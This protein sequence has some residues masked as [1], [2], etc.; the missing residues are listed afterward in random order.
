M[1]G[2]V[3]L[4]VISILA[5]AFF[6]LTLWPNDPVPSTPSPQEEAPVSVFR[7]VELVDQDSDGTTW[8][9]SA[10][11]GVAQQATASA[12]LHGVS[13]SFERRGGRLE[14]KAGEAEVEQG[15]EVRLSGGVEMFWRGYGARVERAKYHR[16]R[17]VIT[18]DARVELTG[19]G[20][21]VAGSGFEIEVE[22][23]I[24]RVLTDVH[25]V[26][27]EEER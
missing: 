25:A 1:L 15:E 4:P 16:G 26:L 10:E 2:R 27:Q 24:A 21:A 11:E 8:R 6:V 18:S 17:G 13:G 14:L 20:L 23:Q 9:L 5:G 12:R 7:G 19:P 3:V 22:E